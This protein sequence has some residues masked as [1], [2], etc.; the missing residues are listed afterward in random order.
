MRIV[1]LLPS[2]TEILFALGVGEDVVGVTFECDFPTEARDRRVV[3]GTTMPEG[4]GPAGIDTWVAA[5]TAAGE[6][7]YTLDA[8]ALS[9]LD[10]DLVLTQDLCAV[11]A[12]DVDTVDDALAHLGCRAEVLSFDPHTIAEIA[13]SVRAIGRAVGREQEAEQLAATVD[14]LDAA[15]A[16]TPGTTRPRVVVLEWTDPPY[17]PG[18]WIPEMVEAAGGECVLGTAGAR[19]VRT[20]WDEVAAARPDLVVVAPCGFDREGARAQERALLA[21]GVLPTGVPTYAVDAN[22]HWARPGPRIVEGVEDLRTALGRPR[23]GALGRPS[24]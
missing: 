19:S 20:T 8:G 3:S 7:L 11:C 15:R 12:I 21:A 13:D 4:L 17:A 24:W 10:P 23:E 14:A 22:A 9:D 16:Q 5:A 18:H 6:D 2:T 1:S